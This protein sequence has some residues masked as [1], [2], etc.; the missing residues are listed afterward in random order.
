V[1]LDAS[2]PRPPGGHPPGAAAGER[3]LYAP[4]G[5]PPL[6]PDVAQ[7]LG[8]YRAWVAEREHG[9]L[10]A[11]GPP[12]PGPAITFLVAAGPGEAPAV[13]RTLR[14]LRN[15]T[16]RAWRLA[17]AERSASHGRLRTIVARLAG[18]AAAPGR[19]RVCPAPGASWADAMDGLVAGV[20]TPAV[21]VLDPGDTLAPDAVAL[22]GG[23]LVGADVAY[24]DEDRVD[25]TGERHRPALKPEWSPDFLL[26]CNYLGRPVAI[27]REM[28]QAAGGFRSVAGGDAEH[29]LLLRVTERTGR[30]AHVAEVLCHRPLGAAGRRPSPSAG[31]TVPGSDRTQE[32]TGDA[33]CTAVDAALAR[34]GQAAAVEPG[35]LPASCRV[36]WRLNRTPSV[37]AVVPFRDGPRFLRA[38]ADSVMA[39][40]G[41]VD[42]ELVLVDNGST[43][44][45][46]LSLMERLG[47]RPGVVVLHDPRPFNWAAL[48]NA[49]VGSCRGEVLL[50]LNNDVEATA[51]G[52]L[53]ALAAQ[54]LRRDVG[55]VGARLLYPGGRVQHAGMVVGLGGAAGH[56][57]GGL[58]GDEPGYLGM[59]VLARDCSAVTGAC[60]ATRRAVFDEL[61][62][63]DEAL[64][65]DLNDVDYCLRARRHGLRVVYEP[66]A[67]LVHHES[68]TRGTSGSAA[69]IRHFLARWE[70][71]LAAG[72]P[73]LSP[74]LTRVDCSCSLRG[75]DEEGW[76][77]RW[78]L[79]LPVR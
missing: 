33:A 9:R 51:P 38:C 23:A 27:R 57:L 22:L 74:H 13:L 68:P 55:A 37:S 7:D 14:S 73:F 42:L 35:P 31:Y 54:A 28:V 5:L 76:W 66:A 45:E 15:Q 1:T 29:D 71:V 26:S 72:D 41:D 58:A 60:L 36:R 53:G 24:A 18:L 70:D 8:R 67:E 65:L 48:N 3:V 62:G 47:T 2:A 16:S 25:G 69:D 77:Q 79:T 61:G 32:D 44:P 10:A 39:T 21:C 4:R 17:V 19:I 56:V 11:A 43:E 49:A 64:G 50:F 46:T 52:W 40:T 6:G 63:F 59:A 12:P 34:R 20:A 30:V 75:P 78:R